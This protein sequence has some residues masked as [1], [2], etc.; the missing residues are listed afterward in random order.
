MIVYWLTLAVIAAIVLALAGYL[1]ATALALLQA[2][3][4]VARLAD[5]LEAV[6]GHTAPLADRV[7]TIDGALR[8]IAAE[9][10]AVEANLTGAADA[11]ER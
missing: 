10:G 8:Q 6:A 11:F 9:F 7:G 1:I 2:R 3:N 5:G 4:N